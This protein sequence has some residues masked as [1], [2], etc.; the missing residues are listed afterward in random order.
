MGVVKSLSDFATFIA[1]SDQCGAAGKRVAIL[2]GPERSLPPALVAAF[3]QYAHAAYPEIEIHVPA[4]DRMRFGQFDTVGYQIGADWHGHAPLHVFANFINNRP[5]AEFI[6]YLKPARLTLFDHGLATYAPWAD[7]ARHVCN[8]Y[9]L[10]TPDQVLLSLSPP[11]ERP[12]HFAG[13]VVAP[14]DWSHIARALGRLRAAD[15]QSELL[16]GPDTAVISGTAFHQL[17]KLNRQE[18]RDAYLRL[19]EHLQA[20]GIGNIVYKEHP[21]SRETGLLSQA[22]GV[23]LFDSPLPMEAFLSPQD[24]SAVY[25]ISSTTLVLASHHLGWRTYRVHADFSDALLSSNPQL[26]A[27]R[28]LENKVYSVFDSHTQKI[29]SG[30]GDKEASDMT[31]PSEPS[32]S[33]KYGVLTFGYSNFANFEAQHRETGVYDINLGDNMQTIAARQLL[34]RAGIAPENIIGIDR[35]TLSTYSG[36][37]VNLV[38]NGVFFEHCFPIPPSIRPIFIGFNAR[39]P[40]I[41]ANQDYLRAHQPI[42]CRDEVTCA[43]LQ[44][45]GIDAYV[46][47]CVTLS[48]SRRS[49]KPENGRLFIIV[50]SGAGRL[51]GQVLPHI[52]QHLLRRAEIIYQRMPMPRYPMDRKD[53]RDAERCARKLLN[54]YKEQ[55]S[56]VLTPLHHAAAPCMAAG[57]PVVLV[58]EDDNPRF[59]YLKKLIPV[60]Q[61]DEF[62]HIDW[63]PGQPDIA[64]IRSNQLDLL[65]AAISERGG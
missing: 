40:T 10:P 46:T 45:L 5:Y 55:A 13:M 26:G 28:Q 51:P 62:A 22:D 21:R 35:D 11:F 50:G 23:S 39:Q 64:S 8:L 14:Q 37:P 43:Q 19:V 15:P 61:P 47:G 33:P 6:R 7:T 41:L 56:L 32:A 65:K 1:A 9:G 16:G 17:W 25:S 4:H 49:E 2:L 30:S 24:P 20:R 52:P 31:T 34:R 48:I 63:E 36:P 54:T 53:I 44:E 38:M 3:R 60:Y 18:E 29:I 57:I 58:R 27:L 59:S 12:T 42:G